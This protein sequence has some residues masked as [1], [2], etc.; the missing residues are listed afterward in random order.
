MCLVRSKR[1][2]G[3]ARTEE[4]D[5]RCLYKEGMYAGFG[6]VRSSRQT[7]INQLHR[8]SPHTP[9]PALLE[10]YHQSTMISLIKT[11]V[12]TAFFLGALAAAAP[13]GPP[14]PG[15]HCPGDVGSE[16]IP[17]LQSGINI[18]W[19]DY[20][21]VGQNP[22]ACNVALGPAFTYQDVAALD[23]KYKTSETW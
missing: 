5:G 12:A 20:G 21:A 7:T 9:A 13:K 17:G 10:P 8:T 11:F 23:Q 6:A 19:H 15:D 4:G 14:P 22:T 2:A 16:D 1:H 18:Y 3:S